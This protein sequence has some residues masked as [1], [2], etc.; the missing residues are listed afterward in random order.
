VKARRLIEGAS[1]DPETL[2]AL[3]QAFDGAW[4]TIAGNFG[5]DSNDVEKARLRLAT[6]LLSVASEH[7]RN[8]QALMQGALQA[9]ALNYRAKPH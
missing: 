2:K 1:Y 8:I 3:G 4:A 9:M 7:G 6:A 5:T